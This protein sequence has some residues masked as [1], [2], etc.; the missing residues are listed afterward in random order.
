[1]FPGVNEHVQVSMA[2]KALAQECDL[3]ISAEGGLAPSAVRY[4]RRNGAKIVLWYPDALVNMGRQMMLLTSYDAIFVKEPHLVDRCTALLGLPVFYLPEACNSRLHRPLVVAGSEP[5]LVIAGSMY[6]SRMRLLERLMSKGIPLKLFGGPFPRWAGNTP[7]RDIHTGR[8]IFGEEKARI[9]R[10]AA[11]VLNNLHP[12]EIQGVNARLFEAAGCG[13]AVLTEYRPALPELFDIGREVLA[14]RDFD[15]LV[16]QA[17][18]LLDEKDLTAQL[19]DAAARRAHR[20]HTYQ[21]RIT[22]IL[23]KVC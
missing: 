7:L 10:S 6:P 23:A 22:T 11:G 4:L 18:R 16:H 17:T 1:M 19:G 9:F 14:F 5:Y 20:D 2:R 8:C 21:R 15:E 3:V 13:A 12:G